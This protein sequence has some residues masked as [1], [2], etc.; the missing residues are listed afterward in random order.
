MVYTHNESSVNILAGSRNNNFLCSPFQMCLCL[1]GIGKEASG[2]D[3]D[4]RSYLTPG[5]VRGIALFE[6]YNLVVAYGNR[7]FIVGYLG[8]EAPQD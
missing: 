7:L 1:G 6:S 5:Q 2:F 3:Y 4:I 8:I